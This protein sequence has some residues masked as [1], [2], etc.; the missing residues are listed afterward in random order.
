MDAG[1]GNDMNEEIKTDLGPDE[2]K[3]G[4]SPKEE[5][6]DAQPSSPADP[7]KWYVINAHSGHEKGVIQ[8]IWGEAEKRGLKDLIRDILMPMKESVVIKKGKRVVE[9]KS[10]FPGYV[11]IKAE[12]TEE[13]WGLIQ[14]LQRV[15]CFLG[16]K[17]GKAAPVP[18]PQKEIDLILGQIQENADHPHALVTFDVG[19]NVRVCDGPFSSFSGLVEEVDPEKGRLKVSVAIFGRETPL[20]LEFSQVE[21]I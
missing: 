20:E 16:G 17:V 19:Q 3:E 1:M 10:F 18:M 8:T 5:S 15:K 7:A 21:R 13:L 12:L 9:E 4:P 6:A 14:G 11:L 2:I